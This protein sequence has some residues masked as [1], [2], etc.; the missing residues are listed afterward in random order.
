MAKNLHDGH[1]VLGRY[2]WDCKTKISTGIPYWPI[3][4]HGEY[5]HYSPWARNETTGEGATKAIVWANGDQD[6][7]TS[8]Y[9]PCDICNKHCSYPVR[10]GISDKGDNY[11]EMSISRL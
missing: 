8:D 1:N 4:H 11:R 3:A 7:K 6:A 10:H 2:C 9:K 5:T